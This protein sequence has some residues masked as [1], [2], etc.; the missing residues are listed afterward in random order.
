MNNF[1]I[2]ITKYLG[3]KQGNSSNANT[4][5]DVLKFSML[6]Q[7]LKSFFSTVTEDL[8]RKSVL[9]LDN[10]KATPVGD[11]PADT[12]KSTLDIHLPFITKIKSLSFEKK[13]FPDDLK[14]AEVSSVFKKNDDLVKKKL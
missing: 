11:I 3:L 2:N 4:L 12:L 13:C 7:V 14:L 6:T 9:N 8:V 10:F 5:E 1:L